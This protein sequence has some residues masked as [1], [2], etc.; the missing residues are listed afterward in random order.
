M[1]NPTAP[2]P[3]LM[4]MNRKMRYYHLHKADPDFQHRMSE[5][6]RRYY[7]KNK[8]VIIA[9]SLAR[10]YANKLPVGDADPENHQA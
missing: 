6:K 1:E 4:N 7:Q 3:D 10:Y 2:V 8:E 9:K 5:A